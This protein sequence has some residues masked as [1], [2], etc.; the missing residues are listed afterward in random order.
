MKHYVLRLYTQM[1]GDVKEDKTATYVHADKV[2]AL[3]QYYKFLAA[4]IDDESK[5]S[6]LC[7]VMDAEGRVIARQ[8]FDHYTE[9]EEAP[10]E[11]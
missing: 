11:E 6:V 10:V 5:I 7:A 2:Q 3:K 1:N 8:K 9:E 4:D